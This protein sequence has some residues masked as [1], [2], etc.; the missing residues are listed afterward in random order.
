MVALF[1][2]LHIPLIQVLVGQ[3]QRAEAIACI[4]LFQLNKSEQLKSKTLTNSES[5]FVSCWH[6]KKSNLITHIEVCGGNFRQF[7]TGWVESFKDDGVRSF[8]V[9]SQL[10]FGATHWKSRWK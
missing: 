1:P 4:L 5:A 9:K 10:A 2:P 8:A 3:S 6:A 7:V